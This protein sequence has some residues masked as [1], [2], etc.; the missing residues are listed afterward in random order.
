MQA[1]MWRNRTDAYFGRVLA[2]RKQTAGKRWLFLWALSWPERRPGSGGS[3]LSSCSLG[4]TPHQQPAAGLQG[5]ADGLAKLSLMPSSGWLEGVGTSCKTRIR[6]GDW[7]TVFVFV[8]V[9]SQISLVTSVILF[10]A[11]GIVGGWWYENLEFMFFNWKN[12]FTNKLVKLILN[13]STSIHP[14]LNTRPFAHRIKHRCPVQPTWSHLSCH[15]LV[16][17]N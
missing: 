11:Y 15:W 9:F 17:V 14:S 7:K 13:S 8:W 10:C 1:R 16:L 6:V 4:F 12:I 3:G 2:L 5:S